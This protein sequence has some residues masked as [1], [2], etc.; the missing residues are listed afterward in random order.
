MQAKWANYGPN[1]GQIWAKYGY[2]S[3]NSSHK[4]PDLEG[5]A[6]AA[7]AGHTGMEMGGYNVVLS[8]GTCF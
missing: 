7:V 4:N 5:E 8:G 2:I 3:L 1:M 6:A